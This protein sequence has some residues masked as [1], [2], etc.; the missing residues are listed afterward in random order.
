ME[1]KTVEVS[2]PGKII[3]SGEHAVVYGYPALLIAINRR[4][5]LRLNKKKGDDKIISSCPPFLAKY[6]LKKISQKLQ[7]KSNQGWRVKIDSTIPMTGG[8]GSSAALSVAITAALYWSTG[9]NWDIEKINRLAYEIEKKQHGNP[10]GGDNT[11]SAYGGFLWY[12]KESE[13][14]KSFSSLTPK[15]KIKIVMIDSGKPVES[16]GDMVEKVKEMRQLD[17]KRVEG[18]FKEM[19]EITRSFL[20]L[21]TGERSY[22]LSNLLNKNQEL[23]ERIGIVSPESSRLIKKIKSLGGA[24]KVSGAGGWKKGSGIILAYHKDPNRLMDFVKRNKLKC[25]QVKLG[26]EGVRI[27]KS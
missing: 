20:R 23:L 24:A 3:L 19:E 7:L 9:N 14:L 21:L 2:A 18:I 27:E 6:G 11:V 1:K 10:S 16:T 12:R 8:M 15:K 26:E 25:F 4:L 17:K 13:D 5:T 22:N